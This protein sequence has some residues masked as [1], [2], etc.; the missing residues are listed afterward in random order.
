MGICIFPCARRYSLEDLS[1]NVPLDVSR[2]ACAS[3]IYT[4]GCIVLAEGVYKDGV[5]RVSVRRGRRVRPVRDARGPR[6]RRGAQAIGFPPCE[7][8]AASLRAMGIVD[9]LNVIKTPEEMR[10]LLAAQDAVK[11]LSMFVVLSDV[12]LDRCVRAA[13]APRRRRRRGPRR[14]A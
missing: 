8:R 3:G 1:G 7:S 13:C 9:P 10:R 6:A 4:E 5:L 11:D 12:H 2:A 14:R